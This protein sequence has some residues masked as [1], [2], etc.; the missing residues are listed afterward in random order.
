MDAPDGGRDQTRRHGYL[1][2]LLGVKQVAVVVNK[3]DRVDFSAA[4]FKEI[5]DEIS[6]HLISLG[7]TPSAVIPISA[8]DGDGVAERTPR[9]QWYGGPPVVEAPHALPPAPPPHHLPPPPPVPG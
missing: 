3:M 6:T 7:V 1:L 9:I 4:R 8:R 5:T 2:H